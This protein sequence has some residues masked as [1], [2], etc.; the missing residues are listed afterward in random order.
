MTQVHVRNGDCARLKGK[1][2]DLLVWSVS[3]LCYQGLI[4]QIWGRLFSRIRRGEWW[5]RCG[6]GGGGGGGGE[7]QQ[8]TIHPA[9]FRVEAC[10][11]TMLGNPE[12]FSSRSLL[13]SPS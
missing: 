13:S 7:L 4:L 5:W 11:R 8:L 6:D 12:Y 9:R 1:G 3:P 10:T 2:T